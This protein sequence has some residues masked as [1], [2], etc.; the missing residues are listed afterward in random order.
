MLI[1]QFVVKSNSFSTHHTRTLCTVKKPSKAQFV[2]LL[3]S[4]VCQVVTRSP[5]HLLYTYTAYKA[6]RFSRN[7]AWT[8]RLWSPNGKSRTRINPSHHSWRPGQANDITISAINKM[9]LLLRD[10]ERYAT[11]SWNGVWGHH[12]PILV[13]AK[14]DWD[15]SDQ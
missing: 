5:K 12:R 4:L 11:S 8:V 10:V 14:T 1:N 15:V 13:L 3:N 2:M 9:I 6:S 7:P